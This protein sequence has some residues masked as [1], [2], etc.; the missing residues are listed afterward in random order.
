[1]APRQG[2]V[3]DVPA[4]KSAGAKEFPD[5]RSRASV[6]A[7]AQPLRRTQ[8]APSMMANT[9]P[10]RLRTLILCGLTLL[11]LQACGDSDTDSRTDPAQDEADAAVDPQPPTP[12]CK[13]CLDAG[14]TPKPSDEVC[15]NGLDD[16]RDGDI[17]NG[18]E[19]K[20][21]DSQRCFR[22]ERALAGVGACKWGKQSCLGD[23][24]SEFR[25][26]GEC[27]DQGRPENEQ[28]NDDIDNDCDGQIDEQCGC[29]DGASEPCS[30]MC[31]AGAKVCKDGVFSECSAPKPATETCN[32]VDDDCDGTIDE[33]EAE[34]CTNSCGSGI[35]RCVAGAWSSCSASEPDAESCNG[36]DDDC[37]GTVDDVAD[38]ACTST[39]GSGRRRCVNGS[40]SECSAPSPSAETCNGRDDDC[41]GTID[42]LAN[43]SCSSACGSGVRSCE[44]GAWSSCSAPQPETEVCNGE[45]DDCDGVIDDGLRSTWSFE[46]RCS[47]TRIFVVFGGC[48]VCA[49][50]CEGYWVDPGESLEYRVAQDTCFTSSAFARTASNGDVCLEENQDGEHV[51]ETREFCNG[52]CAPGRVG[53]SVHDGDC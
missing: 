8:P 5:G 43:M 13:T 31:G 48:N 7:E 1:M 39:C 44:D 47:E 29:K 2:R 6:L 53:M 3:G 18:C 20:V 49:T 12:G 50:S 10:I 27:K 32:G 21:G 9:Y 14:P 41:D 52:N 25:S 37:D 33:V 35:R 24:S 45:D 40:W 4:E 28:C 36:V 15:G 30:S 23:D 11:N 46:N 51:G 17:D 34:P 22:G 26:W 38:M 19:C 16:D 42:D